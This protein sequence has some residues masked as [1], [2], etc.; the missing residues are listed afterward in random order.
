MHF[1]DFIAYPDSSGGV[2]VRNAIR[3]DELD[4]MRHEAEQIQ[5]IG[6]GALI[7]STIGSGSGLPQLLHAI[8]RPNMML[9]SSKQQSNIS[10]LLSQ[11]NN[12]NNNNN[13]SNAL[14]NTP[15]TLNAGKVD[16]RKLQIKHL[17][18]D[19]NNNRNKQ[20]GFNSNI[21]SNSNNNNNNIII[22]NNNNNYDNQNS[23]VDTYGDR[24][25][26][27]ESAIDDDD[28]YHPSGDAGSV[29][30]S[31]SVAS[32]GMSEFEIAN[33]IRWL[34]VARPLI[35]CDRKNKEY[36]WVTDKSKSGKKITLTL[37]WFEG[38]AVI[39]ALS[40]ADIK[41]ITPSTLDG[42]LFSLSLKESPKALKA[43][44]GRAK[45]SLKCGSSGECVKYLQSIR[46]VLH[47]LSRG[48]IKDL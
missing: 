37:T 48:L 19:D 24:G 15:N 28:F 6:A 8:S 29:S 17:L 21:S 13:N 4:R 43:T 9:A 39:G 45:L 12:N 22:N 14:N 23:A 2:D 27:G 16:D 25:Q 46:T 26:G 5:Q 40:Y 42:T 7:G 47:A 30:V 44:G 32:E 31:A 38:D 33:A 35:L 34:S 18:A 10:Q 1:K 20:G 41:D 3:A 11:N 36:T